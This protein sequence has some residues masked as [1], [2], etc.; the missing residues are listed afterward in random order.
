MKHKLFAFLRD[1]VLDK[2]V[3]NVLGVATGFKAYIL[4]FF[5]LKVIN[6]FVYPIYNWITRKV[7][8]HAYRKNLEKKV[9]DVKNAKSADGFRKSVDK[10]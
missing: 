8:V 2:F 1:V 9:E 4:R 5:T 3:F 6:K 7:T 10:L